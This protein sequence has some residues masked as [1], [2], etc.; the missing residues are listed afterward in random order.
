VRRKRGFVPDR[1]LIS[2]EERIRRARP[3]EAEQLSSLARRSKAHR[4]Y[5]AQFLRRVAAELTITPRAI[6]DH[7]V[8][9]LEDQG[10]IIGFHRVIPGQ[11]AVL[12]DLRLEPEAIG[13]GHGRRLWEHAVGVAR[14]GGAS[15]MELD[16]EPHAMGFY[17]RMGAVRVGVTASTV[18]PGRELPSDARRAARNG[19]GQQEDAQ[20]KTIGLLGGMSWE[21]S[22]ENERLMNL[23]VRR[24]LGGNHSADLLIRSYDFAEIEAL[25]EA[26]DWAAAGSRLAADAQ[27]LQQAGAELIVLCTNTM[28]RVADEIEHAVEVPFL[29]LADTTARAVRRAGIGRV[30]LLGTRYTME[31]GV[32][33]G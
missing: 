19:K 27:R 24:R 30:A 15:T 16:A 29:H 7:E 2:H 11:P 32:A 22:I 33:S 9:V 28:H 21:S 6:T 10:G 20:M 31:G 17:Q 18:V 12:E 14:A 8:W 23:E 4:G 3:E 26:G 13:A 1:N 5:D 25:Q